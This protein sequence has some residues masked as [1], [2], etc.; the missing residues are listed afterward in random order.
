MRKNV[1]KLDRTK[2]ARQGKD[3]YAKLKSKYKRE[4]V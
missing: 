4:N 3:A 1:P 2:L